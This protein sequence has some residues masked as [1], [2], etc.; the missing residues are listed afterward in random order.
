MLLGREDSSD[1]VED[2]GFVIRVVF[3][4]CKLID[5]IEGVEKR[6]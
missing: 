1:F 5:G 3:E 6:G 2:S 4:H